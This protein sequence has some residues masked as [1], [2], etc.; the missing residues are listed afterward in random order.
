MLAR[1][2][3][4]SE[5]VRREHLYYGCVELYFL[6][7]ASDAQAMMCIKDTQLGISH[8][9]IESSLGQGSQSSIPLYSLEQHA[10]VNEVY[11][12]CSGTLKTSS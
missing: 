8:I 2:E 11:W 5:W 12:M 7:K 10:L 4:K 9:K 3:A 1:H 6:A